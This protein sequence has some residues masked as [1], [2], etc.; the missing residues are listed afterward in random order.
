[1]KL[2]KKQL[3]NKIT[4]NKISAIIKIRIKFNKNII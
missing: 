4:Q 3:I 1:M 2:S